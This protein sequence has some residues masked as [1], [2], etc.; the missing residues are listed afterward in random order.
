MN[1]KKEIQKGNRKFE[2]TLK[3]HKKDIE[4]GIVNGP[5]YIRDIYLHNQSEF[6]QK[7]RS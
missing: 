4:D 5:R 7:D 6:M 1:L 3:E 2:K